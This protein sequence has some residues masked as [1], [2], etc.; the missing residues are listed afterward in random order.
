MLVHGETVLFKNKLST[1]HYITPSSV[2][3]EGCQDMTLKGGQP[4]LSQSE[5][6][7]LSYLTNRDREL[8]LSMERNKQVL[9][10][11]GKTTVDYR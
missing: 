10:M 4:S 7:G 1:N 3:N 6:R 11:R 9:F 8:F 2:P 5:K